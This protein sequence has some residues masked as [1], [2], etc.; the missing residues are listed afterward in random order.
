MDRPNLH[1][2][3]IP[4]QIDWGAFRPGT[5]FFVPGVDQKWLRSILRKETDRLKLKV[6]ILPVAER[7]LLGV[8]VWHLR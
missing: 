8:R 7:G 6:K 3:G 1:T 2:H 4:F 5:T